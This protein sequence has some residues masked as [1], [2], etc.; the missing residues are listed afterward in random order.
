MKRP[1][2]VERKIFEIRGQNLQAFFSELFIYNK[3]NP[4]FKMRLA[5]SSV[6]QL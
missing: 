6:S 1:V 3:I 2:F 4:I 5:S